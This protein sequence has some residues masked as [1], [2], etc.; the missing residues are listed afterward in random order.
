VF[1]LAIRVANYP[2]LCNVGSGLAR[3]SAQYGQ[4]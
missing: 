4:P 2:C 1:L 3:Q